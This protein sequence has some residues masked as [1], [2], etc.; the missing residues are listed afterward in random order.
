MYTYIQ[1]FIRLDMFNRERERERV[2]DDRDFFFKSET[3]I[4]KL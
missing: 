4:L 2:G 3:N 1:T